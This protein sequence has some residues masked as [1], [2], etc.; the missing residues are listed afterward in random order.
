MSRIDWDALYREAN[1]GYW[2]FGLNKRRRRVAE[3]EAEER[4]R[5][6]DWLLS[7]RSKP[8]PILMKVAFK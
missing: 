2:P 8:E 5:M 1:V 7:D 6:I 4:Q 3:V